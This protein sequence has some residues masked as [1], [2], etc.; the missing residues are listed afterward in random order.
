LRKELLKAV[1]ST[2]RFV[3][4]LQTT[5]RDGL[6]QIE[7][8][9]LELTLPRLGAAF[10]GY[11]LVQISDLHI[12]TWIDRTR[13]EWVVEMANREEPDLV[14]ITGDFV[15]YDPDK[16]EEDLVQVLRRLKTKDGAVAILG[17]HDHWTD[18]DVIRRIL[19]RSD[20]EDLSNRV[21]TLRRGSDSLHIAGVDDVL[22]KLDDLETVLEQLPED[23]AAIL[24]AHEPD[25]VRKS[26]ASGRFDLQLSGHSHGGQVVL[27]LVGPPIL[28]PLGRKYPNGFYQVNEMQLY[29]NRGV[30]T[31]TLRLRINCPPEIAVLTLQSN[32]QLEHAVLPVFEAIA[33]G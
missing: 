20:L 22:E 15:T 31:A 10:H 32:N 1:V 21:I 9:R 4:R 2:A 3:N 30:G 17:N 26:A 11:K 28:P 27:P 14:A 19:R 7:I 8:T 5:S 16:F 6:G 33:G 13:L 18:P 23:G 12:G 24:L 29:T 25:F